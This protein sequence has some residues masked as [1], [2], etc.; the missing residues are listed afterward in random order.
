M[1]SSVSDYLELARRIYLDACLHCVA[2]VSKRDL[3]T[4]RSRVQKQGLSF[5]TITLPDFCADFERS[6]HEG[7]VDPSLFRYFRKSGAIP[8]FLQDMLGRIFDKET[9][10]ITD[11]NPQVQALVIR[12]VRQICLTFKKTKLPCTPERSYKALEGFVQIEN[13]LQL[14]QIPDRDTRD[15]HE[16]S[17][18]VWNRIMLHLELNKMVPRHGPGNTAERCSPN[19]KYRWKYWFDR[20]EPY[21]PLVGNGYPISIGSATTDN[22]ELKGVTVLSSEEELPSRVVQVPKTLKSP[23]TIAI[24]PT[25]TQFV[26]QGIRDQLY[27]IIESDPLTRGHIN[28]ADQSVNQRLAIESSRDGRWATIDLKDASDRVPL[29]LAISMF[30]SNPDVRDAIIACRSTKSALPDGRIVY[31]KKFASM[32]NAL[33]FPV[34][35]M[36]F[37]TICVLALIKKADLPVSRRSVE[38]VSSDVFIY[39]DDIIVPSDAAT[40]VFDYLQRYNCKVNAR[41]T[42]YRG[43]FRESCGVDAYGG[44]D[45]TP[46]YVTRRPPE[47]LQDSSEIIGWVAV[48]NS[49]YNSGY[50]Q[51]ASFMFNHVEKFTG[52]LPYVPPNSGVLGKEHYG[53][54]QSRLYRRSRYHTRVIRAWAPYPVYRKDKL[55]GFAALSKSLSKLDNYDPSAQRERKPLER[56]V[57][58]GAATLK[59]RWTPV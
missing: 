25:C 56:S 2:K 45:V 33:C 47:C 12:S 18:Y 57:L 1:K 24:E 27:K 55:D 50:F 15:F 19:G 17:F 54:N 52:T 49:L 6:L 58:H 23:R 59:R 53:L 28:F 36:Y 5:L 10:R 42:F 22:Q 48:A 43:Y 41:K 8:A 31:L 32:G 7:Q 51:A 40:E 14:L 37:Y 13:D 16:V 34:E 29:D 30:D 4:I 44:I 20:L 26:Q 35:A 9:G 3:R 46:I 38:Q 39:G 21:F 11:E